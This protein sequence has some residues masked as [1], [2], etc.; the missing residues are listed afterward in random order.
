MARQSA[1][2]ERS[3]LQQIEYLWLDK[4]NEFLSLKLKFCTV[5]RVPVFHW[6]Q[7][8]GATMSMC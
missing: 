8:G 3:L 7:P 1:Q 5:P 4:W 2:Y 6:R